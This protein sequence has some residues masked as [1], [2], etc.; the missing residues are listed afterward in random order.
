M[1]SRTASLVG[2]LL[3]SSACVPASVDE[4]SE[5]CTRNPRAVAT[6]GE[7]FSEFMIASDLGARELTEWILDETPTRDEHAA[8]LDVFDEWRNAEPAAYGRACEEAFAPG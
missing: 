2:A 6:S 8:I 3:L 5:W 7:E 1:T 4:A